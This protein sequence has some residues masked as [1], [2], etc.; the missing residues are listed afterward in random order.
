VVHPAVL[1]V[2]FCASLAVFASFRVTG[3]SQLDTLWLA[4]VVDGERK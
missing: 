1:R 2:V 4:L 3:I